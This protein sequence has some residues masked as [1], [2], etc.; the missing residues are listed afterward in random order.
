MD[1]GR[2]VPATADLLLV[3]EQVHGGVDGEHR[4]ETRN[5]DDDRLAATTRH[6]QRL[7]NGCAES[8]DLE[9]NIGAAARELH[10]LSDRVTVG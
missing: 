4:V 5:P 10:D 7:L 8:D 3:D 9:G 1:V 6:L 2:S